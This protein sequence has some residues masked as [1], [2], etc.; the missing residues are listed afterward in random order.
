MCVL[1]Y[2]YMCPAAI[3]V[4]MYVPCCYICATLYPALYLYIRVLILLYICV[5]KLL[6]MQVAVSWSDS[7]GMYVYR[8]R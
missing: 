1:I 8:R 5:L 3:H 4:S 2:L 6:Y 7:W